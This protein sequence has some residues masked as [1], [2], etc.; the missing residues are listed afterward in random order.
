MDLIPVLIKSIQEQ[1]AK[2]EQLEKEI[3]L[4]KKGN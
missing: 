4:L 1:N 3:N 2:I